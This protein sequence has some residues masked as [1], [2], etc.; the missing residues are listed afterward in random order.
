MKYYTNPVNS[1][2]DYDQRTK[3][4]HADHQVEELQSTARRT[5]LLNSH[6]IHFSNE[7]ENDRHGVSKRV[8]ESSCVTEVVVIE[9]RTSFFYGLCIEVNLGFQRESATLRIWFKTGNFETCFC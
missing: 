5:A 6:T 1:P 3:I 7:R 4:M 9:E 8:S 2:R